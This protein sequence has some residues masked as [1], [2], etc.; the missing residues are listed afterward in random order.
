MYHVTLMAK[1]VNRGEYPG[2]RKRKIAPLPRRDKKKLE[3]GLT[4]VSTV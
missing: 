4:G 1:C 3:Y 2:K